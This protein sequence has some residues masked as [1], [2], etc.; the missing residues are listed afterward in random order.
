MVTANWDRASVVGLWRIAVANLRTNAGSTFLRPVIAASFVA[1]GTTCFAQTG[2]ADHEGLR[3][4]VGEFTRVKT[5]QV[6]GGKVD[7]VEVLKC[8]GHDN[9]VLHVL[10]SKVIDDEVVGFSYISSART[11]G[12]ATNCEVGE[13][14]VRGRPVISRD[15]TIFHLSSNDELVVRSRKEG[16]AF[17]FS[18]LT[19]INYCGGVIAREITINPGEGGC[20]IKFD[21]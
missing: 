14:D 15:A 4:I 2:S 3:Q 6:G 20:T 11:I 18:G 10:R 8:T 16:W 5:S 1:C 7:G 21:P 9:G 13:E 17:D 12:L 19:T